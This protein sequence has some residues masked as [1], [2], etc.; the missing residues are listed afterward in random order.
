MVLPVVIG[1]GRL[2]I[3]AAPHVARN[4][5]KLKKIFEKGRKHAQKKLNKENERL[6]NCPECKQLDKRVNP[7]QS[8]SKGAGKGP[9]RGG[10]YGGTRGKG[11]DSN[12]MPAKASYPKPRKIGSHKMPAIQMDSDDHKQLNSTGSSRNAKLHRARQKRFIR[13]GKPEMAFAMDVEDIQKR[14]KGKYD[15]A[16]KEAAAY[17]TCLKHFKKI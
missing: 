6:K 1:V 17:L 4:L 11:Y 5:P 15:E 12:H 10:S 16:L 8:L 7:C 14:F 13:Q 3:A 2:A 9:Y